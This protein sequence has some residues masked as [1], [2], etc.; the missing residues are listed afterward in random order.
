MS[1]SLKSRQKSLGLV[2]AC[3]MRIGVVTV[4]LLHGESQVKIVT[5]TRRESQGEIVT[6]TRR[7]YVSACYQCS[8]WLPCATC[9]YQPE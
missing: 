9:V 6:L 5:L 7:D 1:P 4:R 3:N 8:G 2:R